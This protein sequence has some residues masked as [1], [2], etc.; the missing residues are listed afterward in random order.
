MGQFKALMSKNLILYKRNTL[1]SVLEL[2]LPILFALFVLLV[3]RLAT[4][5]TYDEQQFLNNQ[6]YT[7]TNYGN[8][9]VAKTLLGVQLP[10]I[11]KYI[12]FLY[13]GA[14]IVLMQLH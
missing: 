3:R 14:V 2:F 1:G 10:A 13:K 4:I 9:I 12:F 5:D 11:L 8:P 6:T 7:F